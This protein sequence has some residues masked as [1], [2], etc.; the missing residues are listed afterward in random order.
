V[1]LLSATPLPRNFL[2]CR[3]GQRGSSILE[4]RDPAWL[5]QKY[6][7]EGLSLREIANICNVDHNKIYRQTR[8][9]KIPLREVGEPNLNQ[10]EVTNKLSNFLT[11]ILLGDGCLF[12]ANPPSAILGYTDKHRKFMGWLSETLK[13]LGVKQ[14]GT[15]RKRFQTPHECAGNY[16]GSSYTYT[17]Q[18]KSYREL[19]GLRVLWY[20]IGKKKFPSDLT[21]SPASLFMW[22]IGDGSLMR[23]GCKITSA[24]SLKEL[25]PLLNQIRKIGITSS[26]DS[27]G[28]LAN[29]IYIW[30]ESRDDFF[31]YI[32]SSGLRPPCYA[33]KFPEEYRGEFP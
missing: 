11:G 25:E 17:Y 22:Y 21:I 33:Y 15:I 12:Q 13:S 9:S 7:D 16:F 18:S 14:S 27:Q 30:K 2:R 23:N 29:C 20:P 6:V 5:R 24:K 10:L 3:E 28:Q 26:F 1:G 8:E 4:Y 31:E 32:L 19:L